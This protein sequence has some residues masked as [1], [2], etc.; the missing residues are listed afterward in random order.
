[1]QIN[2]LQNPWIQSA[3]KLHQKKFRDETDRFLVE[4]LRLTEEASIHGDLIHVFYHES[5]AESPRGAALIQYL[6]GQRLPLS[7][8]SSKVLESIAL[9]QTPQGIVAIAQK[10]QCSLKSASFQGK[11]P[12]VLLDGLQE[13]GNLGTIA[14]T[15]WAVG[16]EGLLCL[17]HTTDP[18]NPKA[19]R[20]SM[21]G[22]LALPVIENLSWPEVRQWSEE[23]GYIVV[24]AALE[25]AT[26]YRKIPWQP[27]TI[28]AIGNEARGFFQ[29]DPSQ[30]DHRAFLPL[31]NQAESLNAS[32]AAGILLYEIIRKSD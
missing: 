22:L 21:G 16:G 5:I 26:D 18:Y 17:K 31:H 2:S 28:L 19:L 9:T 13:P 32:V 4:G 24:V 15:L 1:M 14:R 25:K 20:A 30:A 29:I 11:G 12:L 3:R 6:A 8:V 10:K 23:R 27:K 7:K